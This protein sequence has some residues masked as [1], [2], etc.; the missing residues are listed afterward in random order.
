[1]FSECSFAV[2]AVRAKDHQFQIVPCE[3]YMT[4]SMS[5]STKR[6]S[7]AVKRKRAHRAR[8]K[9]QGLRQ[10]TLWLPDAR[11]PNFIA[12]C[13][14]QARRLAA[15]DRAGREMDADIAAMQDLP[16]D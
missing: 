16:R 14:E 6:L 8:M 10:V 5:K 11:D 9:A 7:A 2:K 4:E 13:H 15:Y 12:A 1:M 3:A